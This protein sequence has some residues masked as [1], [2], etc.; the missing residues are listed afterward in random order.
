MLEILN[1]DHI[2]I[3]KDFHGKLENQEYLK[4]YNIYNY[5]SLPDFVNIGDDWHSTQRVS[6]EN[7]KIL[8]YFSSTNSRASMKIT[9]ISLLNIT[10]KPSLTFIKDFLRFV[11]DL[12]ILYGFNKIT[13]NA[14]TEGL[15][16]QKYSKYISRLNGRYVGEYYED[17]ML[18][19]QTICGMTLYELLKKDYIKSDIFNKLNTLETG[20]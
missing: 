17:V 5:F 10:K 20:E 16:N 12:F 1:E 2:K 14:V 8:G 4:Y 7:N 18:Y 15:P 3:L 13:F 11:D 19:D 9:N 6:L